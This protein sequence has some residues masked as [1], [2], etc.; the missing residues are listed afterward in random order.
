MKYNEAAAEIK[1]LLE[2]IDWGYPYQFSSP[3]PQT[4]VDQRLSNHVKVEEFIA[5]TDNQGLPPP[6]AYLLAFDYVSTVFGVEQAG[7]PR[8]GGGAGREHDW[9]AVSRVGGEEINSMDGFTGISKQAI[10]VSPFSGDRERTSLMADEIVSKINNL[11][12]THG[13][14][15]FQCCLLDEVFDNNEE[16]SGIYGMDMFFLVVVS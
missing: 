9:I 10:R 1:S 8:L 11:T 13:D 7:N 15:D 4:S 5:T 2:D 12:G 6:Q 3:A 16:E 14:L